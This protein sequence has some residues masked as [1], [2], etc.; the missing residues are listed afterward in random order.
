MRTFHEQSVALIE[1]Q[2]V[3]SDDP[4]QVVACQRKLATYVRTVAQQSRFPDANGN[5]LPDLGS[6]PI[7]KLLPNPFGSDRHHAE[8]IG[9]ELGGL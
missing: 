7:A 2:L 9:R 4:H 6:N 8:S 1:L 3:G 5:F